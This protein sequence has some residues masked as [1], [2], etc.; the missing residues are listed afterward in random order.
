MLSKL[1]KA[2]KCK[3]LCKKPIERKKSVS[4]P[5]KIKPKIT[6]KSKH[7]INVNIFRFKG[8]IFSQN[9]LLNRKTS[10]NLFRHS[11]A[12]VEICINGW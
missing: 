8:A 9:T 5:K 12:H 3:Q 11:R 2:I 4:V 7:Q 6:V 1:I 10:L